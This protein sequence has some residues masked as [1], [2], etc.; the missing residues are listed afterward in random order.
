[1]SRR[2]VLE[3]SATANTLALN[4]HNDQRPF[5]NSK[6]GIN[7]CKINYSVPQYSIMHMLNIYFTLFVPTLFIV[8]SNTMHPL[9]ILFA[10]YV[11]VDCYVCHIFSRNS[12]YVFIC[13]I[14][15]IVDCRVYSLVFIQLT[16]SLPA[17]R[18]C[19]VC[20]LRVIYC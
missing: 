18:S 5:S 3:A 12:F 9:K 6:I 15:L 8:P 2:D 10:L 14:P 1:M 16:P 17:I 20:C 4:N 19:F 13:S 11:F 7:K